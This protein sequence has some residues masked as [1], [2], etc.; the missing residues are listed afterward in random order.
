MKNEKASIK[1]W[2]FLDDITQAII[3][4]SVTHLENSRNINIDLSNIKRINSS[5]ATMALIK[6]IDISKKLPQ[7]KFKIIQPQESSISKF[8]QNCG[9]YSILENNIEIQTTNLFENLEISTHQEP[10][11]EF[12]ELQNE[13]TTSFPIYHLKYD[14][15]KYREC[16]EEFSEWIEDVLIKYLLKYKVKIN[17]ISKIFKEIAKNSEDHTGDDAYFGIDLIENFKNNTGELKFSFN[18]LG[19]GI[20]ENVRNNLLKN[21]N[22]LRK[23]ANKHFSLTDAYHLAFEAGFTTSDNKRNKGIGMSLIMD[24]VNLLNME[25]TIFDAKSMG[26]IPQ[27]NTHVEIRKN[28]WNTSNDV[29]FNYFGRLIF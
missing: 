29:G 19:S 24:G 3:P 20:L 8:L 28:F 16:V 14:R 23:S 18:D 25:L 15:S 11:I 21:T 10:F 2:P 26:F 22:Y 7:K 5:G 6:L 1:I 4:Y 27:I 9:F 12:R 17:I 13:M